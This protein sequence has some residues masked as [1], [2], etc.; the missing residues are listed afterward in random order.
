MI[1]LTNLRTAERILSPDKMRFL[2]QVKGDYHITIQPK[3]SKEL[4]NQITEE[5]A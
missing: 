3:I 5:Q 4:F 1:L 2:F